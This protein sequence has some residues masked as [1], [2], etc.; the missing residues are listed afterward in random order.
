MTPKPSVT[1]VGVGRCS[2]HQFHLVADMRGNLTV[3][4][5]Q[6]D[7]PFAPKRYFLIFDVPAS[8][9]RGEHA[10]RLCHQLLICV[11][12][13]C[14]VVLD[15]GEHRREIALDRPDLGVYLPPMIWGTQHSYSPN[16]ML[17][18]FAS[19]YYDPGEYIRSYD[20]FCALS[21]KVP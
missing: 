5:F 10:H 13:S 20:E 3:G 9:V 16:A 15:D 18:V 17:L 21:A 19:E 2:L 11:R 1:S 12:G 7:I 4:E 8:E 6:H 14:R